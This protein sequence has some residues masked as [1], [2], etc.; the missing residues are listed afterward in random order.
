MN[1]QGHIAVRIFNKLF[2]KIAEEEKNNDGSPL[3]PSKILLA[4]CFEGGA[5]KYKLYSGGVF[6]KDKDGSDLILDLD[7]YLGIFDGSTFIPVISENI[8]TACVGYA[9]QEPACEITDVRVILQDKKDDL[10]NAVLMKNNKK[11]RNISIEKEFF[12]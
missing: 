5:M 3:D 7:D 6:V 4:V 12:S 11:D 9:K 1:A 2:K 10:P 8:G